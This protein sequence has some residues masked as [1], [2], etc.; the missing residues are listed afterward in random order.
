MLVLSRRVNEK[1]LFPDLG[2]TVKVLQLAGSTVRIGIEAPPEV[3]VLRHELH[4]ESASGAPQAEAP[5]WNHRVRNRLNAASLA[6][7]LLQQQL[8]AGGIADAE[9]TLHKALHE[10]AELDREMT[11]PPQT[12]EGPPK[13]APRALVVEGDANESELLAGLLRASGYE[14]DTASDGLKALEYLSSHRPPDVVL[15]DMRMPRCDGPSTVSA[16]RANPQYQ[17]MKLFAVS[18]THPQEFGVATGRNGVDG[19]FRKP[20]NP[21]RLVRDMTQELTAG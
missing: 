3:R 20:I 13:A 14:V 21:E 7:H 16:I 4:G 19:W 2:V 1:L 17:G 10:F 18:G 6:L 5:A 15:L 12:E 9:A 8:T 11:I